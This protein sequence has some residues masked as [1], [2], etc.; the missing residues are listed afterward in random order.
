MAAT[1]GLLFGV[2]RGAIFSIVAGTITSLVPFFIA[3]KLGREWVE[4]RLENSKVAP[5]IRK[6]DNGNGFTLVLLLGSV[7]ALGLLSLAALCQLKSRRP[8]FGGQ[9]ERLMHV[10]WIHLVSS[11]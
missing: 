4:K 5:I 9:L 1:G 2:V 3:R 10:L 7:F 11:E 6:L 8:G